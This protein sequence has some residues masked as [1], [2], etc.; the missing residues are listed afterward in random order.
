M[1]EKSKSLFIENALKIRKYS[2]FK[3]YSEISP[4]C[5]TPAYKIRM[6]MDLISIVYESFIIYIKYKLNILNPLTMILIN[7]FY[8]LKIIY[9]SEYI[10]KVHVPYSIGT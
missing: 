10:D 1:F 6:F 4:H 8:P 3:Y 5:T 2:E 9:L 7:F